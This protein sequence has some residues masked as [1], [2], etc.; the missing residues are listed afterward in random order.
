MYY[1]IKRIIIQ[2]RVSNSD[3]IRYGYE[4]YI[5]YYIG[6]N[7][8]KMLFDKSNVNYNNHVADAKQRK[9]KI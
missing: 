9:E 1:M 8:Y 3:G 2:F 7:V 6:F 4:A 5:I